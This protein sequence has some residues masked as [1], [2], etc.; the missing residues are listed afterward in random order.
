MGERLVLRIHS[1]PCPKLDCGWG[2]SGLGAI[3]M[4][5]DF[6]TDARHSELL[7]FKGNRMVAN[8]ALSTELDPSVIFSRAFA[9]RLK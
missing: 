6:T 1:P 2:S 8:D 9:G 7:L 5:S 4:L 3:V